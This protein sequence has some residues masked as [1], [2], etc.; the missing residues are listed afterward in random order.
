MKAAVSPLGLHD[1][2]QIN[3]DVSWMDMR[4]W[5]RCANPA[6]DIESFTGQ[7]CWIGLDLASKTDIAAMVVLF[8]HP[9]IGS[10]LPPAG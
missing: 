3:A 1:V 10:R 2:L 8:S 6:L 7:R 5:E 4:A 9:D